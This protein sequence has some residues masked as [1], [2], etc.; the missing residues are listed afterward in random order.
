VYE[1]AAGF[2]GDDTFDYTV[3]DAAGGRST[4]AVTVTVNP[5]ATANAVS[6]IEGGVLAVTTVDGVLARAGGTALTATVQASPRHGKLTVA[7][8]GS[9]TYT[10]DAGFSG[11]DAFTYVATES[12]GRQAVGT[13]T[14][15]VL[16][17]GSSIA[18]TAVGTPGQ[19]MTLDPL[20]NDTA[21][22]G[23]ALDPSTLALVD[24]GTG[25]P[26]RQIVVSRVG[27]WA[28]VNA[29]VV[30]TPVEGFTGR[31]SIDYRITDTAGRTTSATMTLTYPAAVAPSAP[32][33][34]S[35]GT[36]ATTVDNPVGALA[37]TGSTVPLGT[38]ALGSLLCVAAG[39]VLVMTRR[40]R[41]SRRRAGGLKG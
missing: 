22:Q 39:A 37:D 24:P 36:A 5:T 17:L 9:Y 34:R 19:P 3:A 7:A 40:R 33:G 15:T 12:S 18:D 32:V 29:H 4:A 21:T 10:P 20:T 31:A 35:A 6:V 26:V 11:N 13:V 25:T 27:S 28:I 16:Q 8:D 23:S 38:I 2:S 30:F 14:I 41:N 1:P